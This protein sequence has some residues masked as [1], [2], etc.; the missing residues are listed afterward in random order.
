MREKTIAAKLQIKP[1]MRVWISEEARRDLIEPLPDGARF[2]ETIAKANAAV[3][4]VED[5]ASTRA[6]LD[7]N[8]DGLRAPSAFWIAY[9][10]GNR[11]DVNRDRLWPILAEYGLRP[12]SQIAIDD[13]WSALRF[14]ALAEGEAPFRGGAV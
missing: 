8:R 7:T 1:G 13:V 2:V 4:F 12:N 11:T 3:L 6:L 10:K 9:P 5:A 14:R